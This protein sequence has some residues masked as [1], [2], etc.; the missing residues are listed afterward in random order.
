MIFPE[1][2]F[3]KKNRTQLDTPVRIAVSRSPAKKVAVVAHGLSR[4]S[5]T[6]AS[7]QGEALTD[8]CTA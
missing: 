1:D 5:L 6:E 4:G 8:G 7:G 2:N 3:P